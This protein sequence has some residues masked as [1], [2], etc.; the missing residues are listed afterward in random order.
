MT[1][2]KHL[3]Q[4]SLALPQSVCNYDVMH[5]VVLRYILCWYLSVLSIAQILYLWGQINSFVFV[6]GSTG[7]MAT[8]L[9]A[10]TSVS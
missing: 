10:Q 9:R 6:H 7:E 2:K 1:V 4:N 5:S 3:C 8:Y